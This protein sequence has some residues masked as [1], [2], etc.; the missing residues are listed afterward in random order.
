MTRRAIGIFIALFLLL[1]VAAPRARAADS[2]L[3]D[4]LSRGTLR[5]AITP[6]NPPWCYVDPSGNLVGY[7][8]EIAQALG[9]ALGVQVQFV[10][11]DTAGRVAQLQAHKADV[12]ISTFTPTLDRM[13][14]IAFTDP[15][16]IDGMQ[17]LVRADSGI[18]TVKDIPKGARIGVGR[19][20]TLEAAIAKNIPQGKIVEFPGNADIAQAMASQQV[21]AIAANN[22]MITT[23]YKNG[24]GKYKL[25]P[26]LMGTEDDAIGLPQGDFTWWLW[27]NHFVHQIN[28]DGTNYTLYE[29][30]FGQAPPDFVTKPT[31]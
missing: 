15:Y 1:G 19:G 30:W 13:K 12:T 24:N 7:D 22:G 28:T 10:R 29:K 3:A 9:K 2:L 31:S 11:T 6:G 8:A 23:T 21:D 14:T 5:V 17:V 16:S 27:L 26:Q 4:V 20:S 18:N 25:I